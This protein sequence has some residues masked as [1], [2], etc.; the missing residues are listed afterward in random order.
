MMVEKDSH[1]PL[2]RDASKILAEQFTQGLK[3]TSELLRSLETEV[4]SSAVRLAELKIEVG[5][6]RSE[7][8]S[9]SKVIRDG[10]GEKSVISR[11]LILEKD[12]SVVELSIKNTNEEKSIG[13]KEK[14]QLKIAIIT[15]TLAFFAAI[16][17]AILKLLGD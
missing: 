13:N 8:D 16:G 3:T 17:T 11:L 1:R 12:L 2:S 14:L 9:L 15:S 4:H 7:V 6:M 10:N 5:G